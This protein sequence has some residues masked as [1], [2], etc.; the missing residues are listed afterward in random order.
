MHPAPEPDQSVEA[1]DGFRVIDLPSL[2]QMKLRAHR[3]IDRAHIQD[4]LD[5]GLI[6][7]GVRD[8]LPDDLRERLHAIEP[9]VG[10]DGTP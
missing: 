1:S 2:V 5:V 4:L 9:S 7:D 8:A 10:S 3:F 6:D